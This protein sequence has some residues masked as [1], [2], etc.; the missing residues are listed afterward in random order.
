VI[1]RLF[2][3]HIHE[4]DARAM[5]MRNCDST[6]GDKVCSLE[7]Y[8]LNTVGPL[9]HVEK[10]GQEGCGK[11]ANGDMILGSYPIAMGGTLELS[12]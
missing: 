11:L 12:S 10:G 5:N 4:I 8:L 3:A 2:N 6:L 9:Q 7:L 1:K